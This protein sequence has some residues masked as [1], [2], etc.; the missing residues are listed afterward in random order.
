MFACGR[1]E[2]ALDRPL[3][4]GIVNVTPDSF[5][6]GGHYL[7]PRQAIDQGLRLREAGADLL[8]I[9][10]E[11]TRP[12]AQP[13]SVQEELDRV[14]PV[15]EGLRD[16]GAALS[17]DTMK[18]QVMAAALVAGADMI[19]DVQALSAPGAMEAVA[20]SQC[21]ICLMHMQGA[22]RTMQQDPQYRDV[23]AEVGAYLHQRRQACIQAGI[24][25]E[26]IIIDPGF[27]FGKTLAH[28]IALF[29]KIRALADM[30]PVLVG[31]SRK[32]MIGQ[33][34]GQPVQE[35][36]AG[37]VAAAVLAASGGGAILRVHDVQS[38]VDALKIW[39]ALGEQQ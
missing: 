12:G 14:M 33:I 7:D 25:P 26:R 24:A 15:L 16:C 28:N 32:S 34:T 8:D 29:K 3:V 13:V 10:G 6:D 2:F 36:L 35:R 5:S 27:G 31:V 17:V 1:F 9:G 20:A 18:P 22:P 11:S 38:T 37:S 39:Q 21:G 19:N 23:V 4:M 30:A